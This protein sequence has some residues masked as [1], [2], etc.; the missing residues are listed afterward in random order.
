MRRGGDGART[1]RSGEEPGNG[2]ESNVAGCMEDDGIREATPVA[3]TER[4]SCAATTN[5]QQRHDVNAATMPHATHATDRGQRHEARPAMADITNQPARETQPSLAHLL[6]RTQPAQQHKQTE[7]EQYTDGSWMDPEAD[8]DGHDRTAGYGVVEFTRTQSRT[9]DAH[10]MTQALRKHGSQWNGTQ[11][12]EFTHGEVTWAV[13]GRVA[14]EEESPAWIGATAHTN[15]TGELTAMHYALQRAAA[16]APG[17]GKE[18][19]WSDSLYTINMTT[20]MWLPK[21]K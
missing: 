11:H 16:R 2:R 12:C 17:K 8:E 4:Q 15:N 13:A 9:R 14:T 20:G 10:L 18:V 19:I 7:H 1:R 5:E 3:G 21:R 6:R